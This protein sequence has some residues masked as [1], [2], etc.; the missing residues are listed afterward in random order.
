MIPGRQ[1][2]ALQIQGARP[3]QEDDFRF[4]NDVK[5]TDARPSH[6]LMVLADGM[7][8]HNG[9]ARASHVAVDTFVETYMVPLGGVT[10][11][12]QRALERSNSRIKSEADQDD[13]LN[14]MGCTLVGAAFL[15]D[16]LVWISVGDSP[17]WRF[18]D[19]KVTQLNADHSM[20]PIIALRV[21]NG[22]I[23]P[24][25]AA[26]HPYRNALRS[27]LTGEPIPHTDLRETPVRLRD[28]DKFVL[29]SD[30]LHTLS[31][32]EIAEIMRDDVDALEIARKLL[33]AVSAKK[34]RGQDNTTV[35]VVDPFRR[36]DGEPIADWT[37]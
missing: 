12:L 32:H 21:S 25:E 24:E 18:R 34:R 27:A 15:E 36:A 30:G 20:A 33:K 2:A 6:L 8:G 23:S 37:L 13:E 3:Y 17:F 26:R 4:V 5:P 35:I 10:D 9:G 16:G 14:G 1:F 29:A 19:G 31:E 28:G 7:G 22:E 11:R